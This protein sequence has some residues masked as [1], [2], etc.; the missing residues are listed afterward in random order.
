MMPN[1]KEQSNLNNPGKY[2]GSYLDSSINLYKFGVRYYDPPLG[3]W[4]Q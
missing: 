2:V 1:Q 4:T 3:R